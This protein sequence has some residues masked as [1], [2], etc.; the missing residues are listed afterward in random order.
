MLR[1]KVGVNFSKRTR[2]SLG[3]FEFKADG[4]CVMACPA[5]T[6]IDS[7]VHG[8]QKILNGTVVSDPFTLLCGSKPLTRSCSAFANGNEC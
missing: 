3:T 4:F 1:Y 5:H 8:P 2:T 6:I 7:A